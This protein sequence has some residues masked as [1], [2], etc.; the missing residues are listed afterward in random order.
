[1]TDLNE[2]K[3]IKEQFNDLIGNK[4]QAFLQGWGLLIVFILICVLFAVLTPVF[5]RP[6][7]LINVTRQVSIIGIAAVGTALLMISGGIDL[8][9]GSQLAFSGLVVAIMLN[10][11][12]LPVPLSIT[13]T[14]LISVFIGI[15]NAFLVTKIKIPPLIATLGMMGVLRGVG[16]VITGGYPIYS[17]PQGLMV[18]GKGYIGPL[19]IPAL[20]MITF[21]VVGQFFLTK[22]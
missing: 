18:L 2:R 7:N 15:V 1:M 13:G 17:F 8:S 10:K 11:W 20:I 16:Y 5:L 3:S 22:V 4:A 14:L 12:N 19:P 21:F 6:S 9:I